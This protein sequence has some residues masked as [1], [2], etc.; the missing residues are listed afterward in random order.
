MQAIIYPLRPKPLTSK[1]VFSAVFREPD[2][3][4]RD[5]DNLL[6]CLLDSLKHAGVYADDSLIREIHV[7]FGEPDRP[8][9]SVL[10]ELKPLVPS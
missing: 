6:K 7:R 10:V 3:R 4:R 9:G 2:A 5:L 1:L 8:N